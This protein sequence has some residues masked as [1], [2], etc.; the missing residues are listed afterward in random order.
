MFALNY[1]GSALWGFG[2]ASQQLWNYSWS[3]SYAYLQSLTGMS[4]SSLHNLMTTPMALHDTC[5]RT[6]TLTRLDTCPILNSK[7]NR[8][9]ALRARGGGRDRRQ[10]PR[11]GWCCGHACAICRR[12][13]MSSMPCILRPHEVPVCS[14]RYRR[15][16]RCSNEVVSFHTGNTAGE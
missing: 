4:C 2:R 1:F 11:R 6:A 8:A 3:Q 13:A 14:L 7:R 15:T 5:S 10:T 12:P 16:Q 9:H